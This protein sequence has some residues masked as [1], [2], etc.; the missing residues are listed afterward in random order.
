MINPVWLRSFCTLVEVG[1]FTRTAERLYMTQS[2]VSQHVRKLEDQLGLPLLDRQGKRF[3][4]THAGERLY[5]EARDIVQALSD[6]DQRLREDSAYEGVVRLMSPGSVGLKLYPRLL[7]LQ[8][9]H[10]KL[11][12]DYRFAPNSDV[13]NAI[14]ES[15]A[16]IGFMTSPSTLNDVS[17]QPIA[18]ESLLL[19]T[20]AAVTKPTWE[21]LLELGYIGHPD[22]AH[23]AHLLLSANF[24]DFRHSNLFEQRGFSNQIG[25]IL[26][27]VSRGLGFTVLPTHAVGAFEKPELVRTH[28]LSNPVSETLYLATRY[29]RAMPNRMETVL[30]EAKKWI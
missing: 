23:H 30:T 20:P 8:C 29:E 6:L 5:R 3:E 15:H 13:E 18:T 19:V 25:L 12:I 28:Q 24:P 4:L 26:E 11:V 16:D 1:H 27:P 14:A 21:T 9:Q 17:C 10:P 22:G 7:E 2:G